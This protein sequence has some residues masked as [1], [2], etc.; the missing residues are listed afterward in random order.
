[1]EAIRAAHFVEYFVG[2]R[3]SSVTSACAESSSTNLSAGLAN[4]GFATAWHKK[5]NGKITMIQHVVSLTNT[6]A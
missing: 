3:N 1:M 2:A 5:T 4:V 6:A